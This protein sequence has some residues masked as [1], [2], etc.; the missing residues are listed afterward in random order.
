ML[1]A[2]RYPWTIDGIATELGGVPIESSGGGTNDT[3]T[4]QDAALAWASDAVTL[5]QDHVVGTQDAALAWGSEAAAL[6]QDHALSPQDAAFA[7]AA[8]SITA[9]SAAG[10]DVVVVQDT[11]FALA[12]DAV[13]IVQD[14]AVSPQDA[15]PAGA[16]GSITIS[17]DHAIGVQ[18]VTIGGTAYTPAQVAVAVWAYVLPAGPLTPSS[19][20]AIEDYAAAVWETATP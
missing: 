17:Q 11:S 5:S 13:A 10:D 12:A 9:A 19:P 16:P 15:A 14:I 20:Y 8:D 2:V 6:T 1:V 3:V 18:D 4:A 7:L